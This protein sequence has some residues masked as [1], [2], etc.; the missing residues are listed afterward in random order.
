M[1]VTLSGHYSR[2]LCLVGTE[3]GHSCWSLAQVTLSGHDRW[4]CFWTLVTV[5]DH[6]FRSLSL[7]T[8]CGH[9]CLSLARRCV[10]WALSPITIAGY[11]GHSVRWALTLITFCVHSFVALC[12]RTFIRHS[13]SALF[14][15]LFFLFLRQCFCTLP[16]ICIYTLH[17]HLTTTKYTGY[18]EA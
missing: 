17:G 7:I 4:Y 2:T 16:F 15:V 18:S 8:V 3:P 11:S 13:F 9:C 1:L 5:T 10:W 6:F 12:L 14:L